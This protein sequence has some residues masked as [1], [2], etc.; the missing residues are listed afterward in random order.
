[1][2]T[3]NVY[4]KYPFDL[5]VIE[6][7]RIAITYGTCRIV[8]LKI[9]NNI[10]KKTLRLFRKN[11]YG[12]SYKDKTLVIIANE[13]IVIT[14]IAGKVLKKLKVDCDR[15][16]VTA[17]DRIYFTVGRDHTVH[18]LSMDGDE[19]WLHK[20]ESLVLPTGITVDADQNVFTVD[21]A[22]KQNITIQN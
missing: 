18:C 2:K 1:M 3:A 17:K 10:S 19:I 11:C 8:I 21:E 16:L 5:T 6:N 22:S 15:Y 9:E 7:D 13:G 14:N 20:V 4:V 12:I